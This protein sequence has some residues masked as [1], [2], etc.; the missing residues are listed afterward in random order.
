MIKEFEKEVIRWV[1]GNEYPPEFIDKIL[2]NP[3]RIEV[4]DSGAG[5]YDL[6]VFHPKL[7]DDLIVCENT[8]FGICDGIKVGFMA[9]IRNKCIELECYMINGVSIPKTIR[10][11]NVVLSKT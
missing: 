10:Q 3:E 8:A 11:S 1:C 9:T 4:N 7:S 2:D 6:N 5:Q